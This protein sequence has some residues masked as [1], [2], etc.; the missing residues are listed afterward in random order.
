MNPWREA[1]NAAAEGLVL[2]EG[3]RVAYLNPAAARM[4]D[5]GIERAVGRPAA[6]LLRH[7]RL[8]ELLESGGVVRLALHGRRVEARV[9]GER[10]FLRDVTEAERERAVL[11]QERRMLAHE[12]RTPV[13]GLAGLVEVLAGDSG[14]GEERDRALMLLRSEVERLL[15]LVEGQGRERTPPWRPDELRSRL[16]RLLPE[17][18]EVLWDTRH[19]VTVD[20]DRVFQVLLNLVENALHYGRPP[21]RVRTRS[22][23]G[24]V[25]LEV[26]D[27]GGELGDYER[28]FV[29][30]RRGLHAAGIRGS[31]LG[32]A[33]VRRIA[34]GWG[35]EAYGRRS[36][37]GNVFG[38]T[39]PE[40]G[41]EEHA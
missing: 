10:L 7:H 26:V 4:L 12:F 23:G 35:G 41:E 32:L 40:E 38:V 25:A 31:G 3:G 19:P 9:E 2:F 14:G 18:G 33:L 20:R 24:V 11:E 28:L 30:G 37:E 17:A 6:L 39:I 36:G 34:R 27:G 1:W 21:V 8:L 16:E 5:A 13:A 29:P 15:R 22:D